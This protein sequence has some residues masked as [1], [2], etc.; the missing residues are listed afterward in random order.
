MA[1]ISSLAGSVRERAA[2]AAFDAGGSA[3]ASS[4]AHLQTSAISIQNCSLTF[5]SVRVLNGVS[6]DVRSGEFMSILGPSGCGKSTLLRL[7]LGLLRPDQG[8]GI[9][10]HVPRE[11]IGIVFQKP[12][13]MPWQ[14][15]IQNIELP[16]N[17]GPQRAKQSKAERRER[18]EWTLEL[19]GLADFRNHYPQQLSG[20]MQ[21]RIAIARALAANPSILLMDEPFGALDEFTREKL[22]IELLRLWAN[23]DTKLNTVVMVTHSIQESVLMSDRIVMMSPRPA[24]VS[25]IVQVPL[26]HPREA[27]MQEL[28]AFLSTV[29]EI[30][31]Q[32]KAL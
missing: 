12:V 31:K 9:T 4:G 32:V 10:L 6:L 20:G 7:I 8:G 27:E 13:L 5:G 14:T 17:I 26:A 25:D 23:P 30:R 28:P 2:G 1:A 18:A 3:G 16:L 15:A 19:V 21:Q 22:N 24:N 29:R 11:E